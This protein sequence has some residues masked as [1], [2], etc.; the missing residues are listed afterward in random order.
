MWR[1]KQTTSAVTSIM[2]YSSGLGVTTPSVVFPKIVN[3]ELSLKLNSVRIIKM[4]EKIENL[5]DKN[6][7]EKRSK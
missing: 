4:K 2:E 6:I 5:L 7:E 1:P 3:V